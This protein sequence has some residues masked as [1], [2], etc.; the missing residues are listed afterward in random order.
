MGNKI[1]YCSTIVIFFFFLVI[2]FN[3]TIYAQCPITFKAYASARYTQTDVDFSINDTSSGS[4]TFYIEYGLA[5][6]TPGINA[7]PGV[8]GTIATITTT[9]NNIGT[10]RSG[11]APNTTYD[12]Y[13]RKSCTGSSWSA[14][15]TKQSF[16]TFLN[17]G[18]ATALTCGQTVTPTFPSGY[19]AWNLT[20]TGSGREQFYSFTPSVTG[21][22]VITLNASS[23]SV[24]YYW[25]GNVGANCSAGTFNCIGTNNPNTATTINQYFVAGNSYNIMAKP[26]SIVGGVGGSFRLDCLCAA[27]TNILINNITQYSAR[28]NFTG[29][30]DIVEIG[31]S[32][33][34]PGTGANAGVGGSVYSGFNGRVITGLTPGQFYAVYTRNLC[35]GGNIYSANSAPAYFQTIPCP[36]IYPFPYTLGTT[37]TIPGLFGG[38]LNSNV[39]VSCL[40]DSLKY[41][42]TFVKFTPPVTGMYNL[43]ILGAQ[44][45]EVFIGY[46]Q[47]NNLCDFSNFFYLCPF[48]INGGYDPIG[49]LNAG[50]TYDISAEN[51]SYTGGGFG[52]VITCGDPTGV[53]KSNVQTHSATIS[54]SCACPNVSYIEYGPSGF[55]PGTGAT[56]SGG[57]LVTGISPYNLTSLTD[58]K[59]YDVYVRNFCGGTTFSNNVKTSFRTLID[60]SNAPTVVCGSTFSFSKIQ[61]EV[62]N[63]SNYSCGPTNN[64]G[65]EKIFR[66]TP[67]QSGAYKIRCTQNYAWQL[68]ASVYYKLASGSCDATGWT[69]LGLLSKLGD[70]LTTSA[71]TSNTPYLILFD[72]QG[73]S[74]FFTKDFQIDCQVVCTTAPTSPGTITGIAKPCPGDTGV[75]YSVATI[76]NA[77]TYNWT[78]PTGA[79]ITSGI[80]TRSIKVNFAATFVN[81]TISLTASNACGTSAAK[82]KYVSRNIPSYPSIISGPINSVCG[83]SSASYSIN[84]LSNTST[85]LWIVPSG[86]IINS[87]QGT[88]SINLTFPANFISGTISVQGG[89]TCGY[90]TARTLAIR[91]IPATPISIT[92]PIAVC[93]NQQGVSYST[94]LITGASS[95]SWVVPTGA[96]IFSGQGTNAISMNYGSASGNVKVKGVNLCGMGYNKLLAITI[97]CRN[98]IAGN[99]EDISIYPNPSNLS[100]TIDTHFVNGESY[101]LIIKD[102]LGRVVEQYP[103][104]DSKNLFEFGK[105][106]A[107]GL[108]TAEIINGN[109]KSTYKVMKS[110]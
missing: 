23:M 109:E 32:N 90:G 100:F 66:F 108:Y 16:Y 99:E 11:L 3:N 72:V 71:L 34:T 60:C 92:G 101:S 82:T 106:L 4:K 68:Q 69:C 98:S 96:T 5:G 49:P 65:A 102:I 56:A 47:T 73:G 43:Q 19:G 55:T 86:I 38:H 2:D 103:T 53:N 15:T 57:T 24:T 50:V 83:G 97:V 52:L 74:T 51:V 27:P 59:A 89:T 85:Y 17:C 8:G 48:G 77:T 39:N 58:N 36:A 13:T 63:W 7:S 1:T 84:A 30:G 87:G 76:A 78:M 91:S 28:I 95:Y 81:G 40:G 42:E 21:N 45:T 64:T 46:R 10:S 105:S 70:S 20:C 93:A 62:G 33:F 88:T 12:M 9:G 29:V 31:P 18:S 35:A 110:N 37:I 107:N 44:P 41:S 22:Q 79:L 80:G 67:L 75:I 94:A 6:F 61:N 26:N 54:F 25:S 14:N 104:I